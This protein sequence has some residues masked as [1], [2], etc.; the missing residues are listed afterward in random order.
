[1]I[2][3]SKGK[4][5]LNAMQTDWFTKS[6]ATLTS[7]IIRMLIHQGVLQHQ[8]GLQVETFIILIFFSFDCRLI[9]GC[10]SKDPHQ[11]PDFIAVI[12]TLEEVSSSITWP[13]CV[14]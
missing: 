2:R 14:C 3:S 9:E 12:Q 4:Y 5:T 6:K 11:R 10:I 8:C 7:R 1:M 13:T